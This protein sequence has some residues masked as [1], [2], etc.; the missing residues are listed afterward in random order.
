METLGEGKEEISM[1]GK[2]TLAI[3]FDGTLVDFS[4]GWKGVDVCGEP[5]P[6]AVETL[7]K[8]REANFKI[9]IY[10]CRTNTGLNPSMSIV[11]LHNEFKAHLDRLGF[12]YDEIFVGTGKPIA[13]VYIDDRGFY[14]NGDW[15]AVYMSVCDAFA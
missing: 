12:V 9:I 8:F 2:I 14:F 10:S 4:G 6:H 15:N 13:H 7:K 1:E 11:R 5:L 3:D